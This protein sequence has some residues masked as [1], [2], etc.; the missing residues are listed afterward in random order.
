MIVRNGGV[1]LRQSPCK[2]CNGVARDMGD[3]DFTLKP[4]VVKRQGKLP[5][6]GKK[7]IVHVMKKPVVDTT[8]LMYRSN[9]NG[10]I[11]TM[12][13]INLRESHE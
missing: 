12:M 3:S 10:V 5:V 4:M 7:Q 6:N 13:E 1:T 8:R 11:K 2:K 9:I